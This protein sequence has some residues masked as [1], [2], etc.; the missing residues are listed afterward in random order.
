MKM[1]RF[2][3]KILIISLLAAVLTIG[4][5]GVAYAQ[6]NVTGEDYNENEVCDGTGQGLQNCWGQ[7]ADTGQG[8]CVRASYGEQCDGTGQGL[9][10]CWGKNANAGQRVGKGAGNGEFCN[11]TGQHLQN[12]WEQNTE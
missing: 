10:N 7:N 8:N 12:C 11:G 3:K 9:Q 2:S 1:K 6:D 5:A 4:F